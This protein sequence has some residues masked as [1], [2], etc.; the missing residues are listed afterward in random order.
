MN[1]RGFFG[2]VGEVVASVAIAEL[3]IKKSGSRQKIPGKN[4]TI[5]SVG[6]FSGGK[7]V[8]QSEIPPRTVNSGDEMELTYKILFT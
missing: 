1:R 6:V 8:V 7:L 2:I 4:L 5:D 3:S